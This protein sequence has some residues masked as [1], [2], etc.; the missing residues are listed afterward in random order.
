MKSVNCDVIQD[1]LPSYVDKISSESTNKLVEEHLQSCKKCQDA[2]QSM[3]KEIDE[4]IIENQ[5]EQIDYLKG[6]RKSKIKS[7]IKAILIFI[8]I[9]IVVFTIAFH[10]FW[11]I[12]KQGV[13]INVNDINVEYTYITDNNELEAFLYSEKYKYIR[14]DTQLFVVM[15]QNGMREIHLKICGRDFSYDTSGTYENVKLDETIEKIYL[16]DKRGHVKEI[17]N[18]DIPVMMEN[19]W[20]HWYVDTYVPQEIKEKYN[21]TYD[22]VLKY[23]GH[24]DEPFIW[25]QYYDD[26][27]KK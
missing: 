25:R 18:K 16:E 1:L 2:L 17:W 20:K 23:R 9:M 4:K 15:N 7:N 19:E 13:Y 12:L 10:I 8:I 21:I 3:S 11:H 24:K 26:Y 5:D 6:F 27:Y 22:N 14:L